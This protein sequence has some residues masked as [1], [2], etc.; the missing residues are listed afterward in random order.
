VGNRLVR[1]NRKK[2]PSK[3]YDNRLQIL[4]TDAFEEKMLS[5]TMAGDATDRPF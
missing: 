4:W 1:S 5:D 3:Q 2:R